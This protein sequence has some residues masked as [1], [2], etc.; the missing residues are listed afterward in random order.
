[1]DGASC[2]AAVGLVGKFVPG[3]L[4]AVHGVEPGDFVGATATTRDAERCSAIDGQ[5][6]DGMIGARASM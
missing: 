3:H 5:T 4:S 6:D 1:M 2:H